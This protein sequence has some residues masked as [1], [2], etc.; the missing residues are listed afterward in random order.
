MEREF[1]FILKPDPKGVS[2]HTQPLDLILMRTTATRYRHPLIFGSLLLS[3]VVSLVTAFLLR[4]EFAIPRTS[5]A[6][7]RLGLAIAIPLKLLIFYATRMHRGWLHFAGVEDLKT[8]FVGTAAATAGFSIII[9]QFLTSGTTRFPRSV[10][11]MDFILTLGLI[12]AFRL[13]IRVVQEARRVSVQTGARKSVLIYGAGLAGSSLAR[14]IL[15]NPSLGYRV[16]GFVDD[17]RHKSNELVHGLP[18]LGAGRDLRKV[19]D[20]LAG[21]GCVVQ[22]IL[23][24]MPSASNREM[25]QGIAN[26]RAAELPCKTLPGLGD[27]LVNRDLS[28]QIRNIMVEDLLHREVIELDNLCIAESLAERNVMVTGAAGSIGSELCRQIAAFHPSRLVL[29]DHAESDLFRIDMELRAAFPSLEI[30]P[31]VAS[32][33]DLHVVEEILSDY[34][35]QTIFH[36][37][38][39]KHVP[40]M[41]THVIEAIKNNVIG[42]WNVAEAAT[43]CGV[44]TFVMI[45]SDKAVNPTNVMGA[46]KRAA[47]L[48]VSSLP[49]GKTRFVSVRFGNVLGSNGSV[50]PIFQSQIAAGG[51][52]TVTHP[53]VRRFFMTV[54]EAVQLVLQ[55]STMGR[56][57]E[58]YVLDMGEPVRIVDLARNMIRLAGL[59]PDKDVK[60]EFTGLRPGEKLFEELI[61]EG[62]NILP[63]H[64]KKIKIFQG[65]APDLAAMRR[66]MNDLRLIINRQDARAAVMHLAGLIPEYRV[67]RGW[68]ETPQRIVRAVSAS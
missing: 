17:D 37:A 12:C 48:L 39:Y 10:L 27:L 26:C 47:E 49:A 18:I 24:A 58:I 4:F 14:E 5:L 67:S 3:I 42:T 25:R 62:E 23:I 65:E 41:E 59:V 44:D 68:Q 13:L 61:S 40:L 21:T 6:H 36:A 54:R 55:A 56:G 46:T 16:V 52:V 50:V 1:R 15:A 33:R 32:I 38:A 60:I 30:A 63:T 20:W 2:V 53:E 31:V 66:W 45:S 8:I 7:L 19:V 28:A 22:E 57:S 9:L 51:P 64:H 35:V 43:R 29:L 34:D 11:L